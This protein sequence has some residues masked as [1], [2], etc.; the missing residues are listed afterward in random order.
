MKY[1]ISNFCVRKKQLDNRALKARRHCRIYITPLPPDDLHG[2][3][4]DRE[5]IN[6]NF[7]FEL[8]ELPEAQKPQKDLFRVPRQFFKR[9]A[10]AI[11]LL[12]LFVARCARRLLSRKSSHP[13]RIAFYGGVLCSAVLCT[14]LSASIVL[15][16]LFG[17]FLFDFP[18]D[19]TSP[20]Q[21]TPSPKPTSYYTVENFLG[22][23]EALCLLSLKNQSI[24]F[25]KTEEYSNTVPA[26]HV[27]ST[28]P[29]AG[30]HL[31]D[32]QS[33]TLKISLGK[34]T[35]NVRVPELYG[36]S[37]AA[38]RALLT[39]RGLTLGNISY[40]PS[41]RPYGT[42]TEQQYSPY[43]TIAKGTSINITVS[44]GNASQKKIPDLYGMTQA[45]AKV[46]LASVG[47]VIGGI[48]SAQSAAQKG[49]VVVQ[50]PPSGTPITSSITSVDIYL[51]S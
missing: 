45:E 3:K 27:I 39:E 12:A 51:S 23:S 19:S 15:F 20:E 31:Y 37:E 50:M 13:P 38:A 10:H 9:V 7:L 49:I 16:G 28:T 25:F 36:L 44:L 1:R 33:L 2:F 17:R 40:K 8:G 32:G 22:T 6:I 24:T 18:A 48:F 43:D 35:V 34:K 47:L 29:V 46:A 26:G 42:V 41:A 14:L 4:A 5:K 11:K 21:D 30:E